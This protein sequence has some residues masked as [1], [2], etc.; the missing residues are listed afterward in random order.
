VWNFP[1]AAVGGAMG[2]N[3]R[4]IVMWMFRFILV[5]LKTFDEKIDFSIAKDC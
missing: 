4:I 3:G 2:E 5:H 1:R